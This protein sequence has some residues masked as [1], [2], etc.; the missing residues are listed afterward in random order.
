MSSFLIATLLSVAVQS[1]QSSAVQ[2]PDPAKCVV[3]V[4]DM[5]DVG[6]RI[7]DAQMVAE[8]AFATFKKRLGN[9]AVVYE[10]VYKNA[11]EMKKRLGP[12]AENA[13]QDAQLA[14]YEACMKQAPH[15]VKVTFG[16]KGGK[17]FVAAKCRKGDAVLDDVKVEAATF[18]AARDAFAQK[19]PT[20]CDEVAPVAATAT[21]TTPKK[22]EGAASWQ[23]KKE[24]SAGWQPPPRRE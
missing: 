23:R 4:D 5:G 6:L 14:Y 24:P 20:F 18:Q 1:A 22:D 15:R 16:K 2:T 11:A 19:M 3:V 8:D 17:H 21:T 7:S 10:G 13:I 12:N 9:D